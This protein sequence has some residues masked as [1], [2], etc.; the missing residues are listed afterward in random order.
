MPRA[1]QSREAHWPEHAHHRH[2]LA[3]RHLLS[4]RRGARAD[5]HPRARPTVAARATEGPVENIKLLEAG[6]IQ[7][8]FVTL[9]I[10]QQGWNGTGEWTGG[11]QFR[12]AR[13]M[14]PMYDTPFQFVALSNSGI[15]SIAD[16]GGKRIGIGPQGG[17]GG[18]YMPQVFKTMNIRDVS[19]GKLDRSR[20][21]SSAR[22]SSTRWW[23]WAGVPV[24]AVADLER[25]GKVRYLTPG[26]EPDRGH[27][28][29]DA[30]TGA[31]AHRGRHLSVAAAPLSD[32][33]DVQFRGRARR[34]A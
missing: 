5:A 20:G 24:P 30:G 23:R 12:S 16:L 26:A 15:E 21:P 3:R 6:E 8:A 28:P 7:L 34:S 29:G 19:H 25:K 22:A 18:I 31:F 17:T 32:R 13:A 14:F 33:R 27:A 11:K 9:G 10:A 2:R 4:V 1:R